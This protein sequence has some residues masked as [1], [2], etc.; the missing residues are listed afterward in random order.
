MSSL[1][2][3]CGTAG[4]FPHGSFLSVARGAGTVAAG[5]L[6][7]SHGPAGRSP[8]AKCD[9]AHRRRTAAPDFV[10]E[11]LSPESERRDLVDKRALYQ[12]LGVR[13]YWMFDETRTRLLDESGAPLGE[14]LVGYRLRDGGYRRVRA[15]AAGRWPSEALGLE[16]CVRHGPLRFF[17]PVTREYLRTLDEEKVQ[18]EAAEQLAEAERRER[19][20]A[21]RRAEAER[22]E[23][24]AAERRTDEAQARVAELEATLRARGGGN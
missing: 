14:L 9:F 23:R 3:V 20:A 6:A 2:Q 13:E 5:P 12:R 17:D 16:L 1:S 8:T 19:E 7:D 22:R 4:A 18:R 11:D 15:N 21:E 24:E 10:L